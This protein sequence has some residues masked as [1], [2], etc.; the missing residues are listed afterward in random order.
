MTNQSDSLR[1][2]EGESRTN[3]LAHRL[4]IAVRDA[5]VHTAL[6]GYELAG[7]SGL[8]AEGRWEV[9]VDAMVSLELDSVVSEVTDELSPQQSLSASTR[10][11]RPRGQF[12]S[13]SLPR[14][15]RP[16]L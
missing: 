11:Q 2:E 8:C 9:A 6:E 1:G 7:L 12:R 5:C 10:S 16:R 3:V 13:K 14:V 15:T 4:A